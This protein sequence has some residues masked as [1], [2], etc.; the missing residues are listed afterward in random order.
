MDYLL[1][2]LWSFWIY[3]KNLIFPTSHAIDVAPNLNFSDLVSL[4]SSPATKQAVNEEKA[5]T[6]FIMPDLVGDCPFPLG[7]HPNADELTAESTKWLVD[8][9]PELSPKRKQAL[10]GLQV[11]NFMFNLS[12]VHMIYHNLGW[13]VDRSVLPLLPTRAHAHRC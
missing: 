6:Y 9:C 8:G 1:R 7:R 3:F 4:D 2:P 11:R 12:I 13:I 10:W 5:P